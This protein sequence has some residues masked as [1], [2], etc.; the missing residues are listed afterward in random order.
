M[1]TLIV[2][3]TSLLEDERKI[4]PIRQEVIN[5]GPPLEQLWYEAHKELES[6][7]VNGIN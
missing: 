6:M 4:H 7:R 5:P 3:K 1:R 2:M